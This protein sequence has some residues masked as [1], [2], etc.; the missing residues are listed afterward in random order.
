MNSCR[1]DSAGY[2]S[3]GTLNFIV[4][5]LYCGSCTVHCG[6]PAVSLDSISTCWQDSLVTT[7]M[8]LDVTTC[9]MGR[10]SVVPD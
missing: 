10:D 4:I 7:N 9:S 6:C 1:E 8:T 5:S 2:I 3:F